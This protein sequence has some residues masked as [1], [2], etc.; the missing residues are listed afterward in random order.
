MPEL[1]R[2]WKGAVI[3]MVAPKGMVDGGVN[4]RL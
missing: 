1:C 3:K 2:E 4:K